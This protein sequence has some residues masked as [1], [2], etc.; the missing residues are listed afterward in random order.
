MTITLTIPAWLANL[1]AILSVI[2]LYLFFF[3]C[4]LTITY[5]SIARFLYARNIMMV[6]RAWFTLKLKKQSL[7]GFVVDIVEDWGKGSWNRVERLKEIVQDLECNYYTA[8]KQ[9]IKKDE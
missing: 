4:I 5:W 9:P 1:T 2:A 3:A 7:E 6:V 8:E